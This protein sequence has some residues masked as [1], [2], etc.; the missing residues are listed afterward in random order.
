MLGLPKRIMEYAEALPEATPLCPSALLHLG[1]RASVDQALSRLSCVGRLIRVSHGVYMRP[2]KTSFGIR[3]PSIGKVIAA[4]SE[5]WGETIV[6]C[7]GAAANR[8]GL[9][10]QNPVRM[11][12]LTSGP[13]RRL[14]FGTTSVELRHSPRWQLAAPYRKAGEVIRALAWLGPAEVEESLDAVLP[15]LSEDELDELA[16]ARAIVPNWLAEPVST[17]L[18]HGRCEFTEAR[19]PRCPGSG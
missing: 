7:G 17:K 3:N 15:K 9:T 12:Y 14:R 4:L 1:N 18:L 2:I 19:M 10:T 11:V 16:T 6:P 8:L 13:S 5:L